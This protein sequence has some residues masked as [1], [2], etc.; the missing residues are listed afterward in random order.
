[1]AWRKSPQS[2]VDLFDDVVPDRP[3]MERRQMYVYPAAFVNG[4]MC[5]GLNQE[6]FI[7]RLPPDD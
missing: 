7:V 6:D 2:L 1:M 5:M 3:E 4:D